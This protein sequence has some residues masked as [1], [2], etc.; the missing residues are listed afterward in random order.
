MRHRKALRP[1]RCPV[2]KSTD[3]DSSK[4]GNGNVPFNEKQQKQEKKEEMQEMQHPAFP[5]QTQEDSD[6]GAIQEI[7]GERDDGGGGSGD[8]IYLIN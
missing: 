8:T 4:E 7:S 2:S 5:Q 6:G 3:T 1:V